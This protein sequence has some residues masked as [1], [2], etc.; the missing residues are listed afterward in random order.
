MCLGLLLLFEQGLQSVKL[1]RQKR[2]EERL[3]HHFFYRR[4]IQRHADRSCVV[5]LQAI[6]EIADTGLV[7]D[8]HVV[9][10]G[11]TA[12]EPLQERFSFSR[13]PTRSAYGSLFRMSFLRIFGQPCLIMEIV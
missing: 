6:T 4:A 12:D 3:Y 8:P 7:G 13:G 1:C 2:L 10:A 5:T 9:S 11:P